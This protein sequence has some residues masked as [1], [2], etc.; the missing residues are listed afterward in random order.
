MTSLAAIVLAFVFTTSISSCSKE[1]SAMPLTDQLASQT[2]Y[3]V[4]A[5]TY[6]DIDV[7]NLTLGF[8]ID[9]TNPQVSLVELH[10]N[11]L[12]A[13]AAQ[14]ASSEISIPTY[15][16]YQRIFQASK[17]N[18]SEVELTFNDPNGTF[19]ANSDASIPQGLFQQNLLVWH[20]NQGVSSTGGTTG[21]YTFSAT[22][23]TGNYKVVATPD[24]FRLTSTSP[25]KII[26]IDLLSS[27]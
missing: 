3:K 1:K 21:Y 2:N 4:A 12:N 14:M 16:S 19:A 26:V 6:N 20:Q 15:N 25:G 23:L 11:D 7:K 17:L 27:I 10:L 18:G 22:Q 9:N 13:T 8:S 5:V 24:G